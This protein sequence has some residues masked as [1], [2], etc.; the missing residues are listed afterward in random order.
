M[1]VILGLLMLD[2]PRFLNLL[3]VLVEPNLEKHLFSSVLFR[4][5]VLPCVMKIQHVVATGL[6]FTVPA[7]EI[8]QWRRN[9]DHQDWHLEI[10]FPATPSTLTRAVTYTA[11]ATGVVYS[12]R[13][14]QFE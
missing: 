10:P 4:Q 2:D 7:V 3:A 14:P 6:A 13:T 9:E 8:A 1:R 12:F 11:T 5:S